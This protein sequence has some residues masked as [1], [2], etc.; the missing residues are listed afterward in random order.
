[1]KKLS[2]FFLSLFTLSSWADVPDSIEGTILVD[3]EK[4]IELVETNDNL[5][6]IDSRVS[7][8]YIKGHIPDAIGLP[9]TETTAETLARHI[10]SK[11]TPVLFYCNGAKCGR[12]V[13]ACNT[14]VKEGYKNVYW[15]RTGWV[16][17]ISK[18]YPVEK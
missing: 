7:T 13:V 12:S 2:I 4:V 1:M 5:V 8:D 18:G 11:D 10:A 9:D 3:A 6:L 16:E 17:W 14:A 15:F